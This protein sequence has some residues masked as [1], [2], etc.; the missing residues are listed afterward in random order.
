[1]FKHGKKKRGIQGNNPIGSQ[2]ICS[3]KGTIALGTIK[4]EAITKSVKLIEV[5]EQ[6]YALIQMT[7][8]RYIALS[9]KNFV[10]SDV[11]FF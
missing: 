1:M 2:K 3:N 8:R 4:L 7:Q 6:P 11:L 10:Q 5:E 9:L